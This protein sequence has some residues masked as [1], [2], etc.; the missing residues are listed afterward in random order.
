MAPHLTFCDRSIPVKKLALDIEQLRVDS[1][2]TTTAK[3]GYRGTVQ[4]NSLTYTMDFTCQ[5]STCGSPSN[6]VR[7]KPPE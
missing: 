3:A 6:A 7:C 4:G 5:G 1:Y 2:H